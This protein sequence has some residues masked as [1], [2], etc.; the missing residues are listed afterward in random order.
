MNHCL[1]QFAGFPGEDVYSFV[2]KG[3]LSAINEA[4]F[5]YGQGRCF[6]EFFQGFE[7]PCGGVRVALISAI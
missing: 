7:V 1:E 5:C 6:L 2:F 3:F 4:C